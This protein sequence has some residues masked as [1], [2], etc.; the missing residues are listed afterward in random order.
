MAT[1]EGWAEAPL[2]REQMVLFPTSIDEVIPHDHEVR[3][4]DEVLRTL[5]WADW[6]D[7]YPRRKGQ[8]PIHPRVLASLWLYGLSRKIKASRPLEYACSHNIDFIWLAEGRRPD[9]STLAAFFTKFGTQ[10][11]DLFKQV[12]RLAVRMGLARLGEVAF[13]GTRVKAC[14]GRY[15]TLTGK[16]LA[17]RLALVDREIDELMQQAQAAQAGS[18]DAGSPGTSTQLPSELATLEER[19]AKLQAALERAN[20]LDEERRKDGLT[21]PAQVPM[22]DL[23][24]RVMPNKEG[25]FAPNFTPT[26]LTDGHCGIILETNVLDT[27]NEHRETLPSIDAATETYGEKLET[28]LADTTMS[29]GPILAG[30]EE[31]GI[32]GYLPATS[33]EPPAESPVLRD[34]WSLPV[35]EEHR[36]A[37]PKN[38][39]GQLDRSNFLY[40]ADRD[41]YRCP[42]GR[43]LPYVDREFRDGVES[44]RYRSESCEDCPLASSCLKPPRGA[45]RDADNS[46]VNGRRRTIRRDAHADARDRMAARMSEASSQAKF[47]RRSW[48]A[49]TPFAWLKGILGLRQFRHVGLEK[50]EQ[51]WRWACLSLNVKKILKAIAK[52]RALARAALEAA[53]VEALPAS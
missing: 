47:D 23:E 40:D 8:P 51:E 42:M 14:N 35:L 45:A 27:V 10:L 33:S 16:T 26:A 9:H 18:D 48:V 6:E 1:A 49:E 32:T 17:E 12:V 29:T 15:N 22:N 7:A 41:E 38:S 37:L 36:D 5:D 24:S 2:V 46:I 13:D 25:G 34:D 4:L 43:A 11:K 44:R 39:Q 3:L 20:E 31:R 30:L 21:T 50:V 28:F 53:G 19:R 52:L